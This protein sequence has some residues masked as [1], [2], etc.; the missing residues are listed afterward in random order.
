MSRQNLVGKVLG[1]GEARARVE[2]LL[3]EQ[4]ERVR[5]VLAENQDL[6]EALRDSLLERDELVGEEI[7][8]VIHAAV[9]RRASGDQLIDLTDPALGSPTSD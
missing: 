2:G 3:Q 7:L 5:G 9:A 4:K 8:S 1:D 6:L